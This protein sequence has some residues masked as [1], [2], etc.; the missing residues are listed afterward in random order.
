MVLKQ[1]TTANNKNPTK[2]NKKTKPRSISASIYERV[3][4]KGFALAL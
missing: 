1:R 2:Q 3:T 4:D